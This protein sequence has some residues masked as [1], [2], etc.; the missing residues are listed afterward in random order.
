MRPSICFLECGMFYQMARVAPEADYKDHASVDSVYNAILHSPWR[1]T[2]LMAVSIC[3]FVSLSYPMSMLLSIQRPAICMLI[4]AS[5]LHD[6]R[7]CSTVL[8]HH[9]I[10]HDEGQY[11]LIC[12]TSLLFLLD[13]HCI[14]VLTLS[15]FSSNICC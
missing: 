9:N 4:H 1:S 10:I 7:T 12:D 2:Y 6:G 5:N 3:S 8:L 14:F 15:R 13:V 11:T